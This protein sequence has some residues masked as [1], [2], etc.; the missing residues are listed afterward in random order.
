[1]TEAWVQ[2]SDQQYPYH[3]VRSKRAKYL[4]LKLSHTGE[5][6]VVVPQ[7]I[8]LKR[9]SSFVESQVNWLESKLPQL[10]LSEHNEYSKPDVLDLQYLGESWSIEYFP[11]ESADSI[12]LNPDTS[13]RQLTCLGS[14]DDKELLKKTI[15]L[16]LKSKAESVIPHRL[17]ELAEIHGFHYRRVT[18]RGQKTRWGSCS[19]QKNIN[20]NYK[21]LFL[22][23]PMV[24]YVLIHELCHT[25]EMNHSKRFW[26]LVADCDPNFKQHDKSLNDYARAIPV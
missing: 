15:G 17:S 14:V 26:E 9:A 11:D 4:R 2:L 3:F 5:L 8:S 12:R 24:D 13:S 16:W 18:I 20:L 22:P 1:M 10:Q 25:L 21:L 7:G 23:A 6:S 19:S